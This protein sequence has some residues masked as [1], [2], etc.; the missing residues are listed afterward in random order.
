[1]ERKGGRGF[2]AG[3]R[4][5]QK[6]TSSGL[7]RILPWDKGKPD[8]RPGF[9]QSKPAPE[10]AYCVFLVQETTGRRKLIYI[11]MT[12]VSGG[13]GMD[14]NRKKRLGVC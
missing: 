3:T 9:R 6:C 4:L 5:E 13:E 1:M 10:S 12:G 11:H 8:Q 7:V 2:P 14:A